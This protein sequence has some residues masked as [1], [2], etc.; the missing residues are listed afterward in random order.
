MKVNKHG[1]AIAQPRKRHP[2]IPPSYK[3]ETVQAINIVDGKQQ[4]ITIPDFQP[5]RAVLTQYGWEL[6]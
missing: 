6:R 4:Q 1:I 3:L 2:R 5:V